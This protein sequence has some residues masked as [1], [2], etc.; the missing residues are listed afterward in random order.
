LGT[1]GGFPRVGPQAGFPWRV[2]GVV[3]C[4]VISV[5]YMGDRMFVPG[6]GSL[7]R[8]LVQFPGAVRCWVPWGLPRIVPQGSERGYAQV[9]PQECAQDGS[10]GAPTRQVTRFGAQEEPPGGELRRGQRDAL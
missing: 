6:M 5:G 3:R 8:T 9:V 10:Q 2:S 4:D 1:L 7:V